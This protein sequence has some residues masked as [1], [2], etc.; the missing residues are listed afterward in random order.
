MYFFYFLNKNLSQKT[1]EEKRFAL[2]EKTEKSTP[3]P[4]TPAPAPSPHNH[5]TTL[6]NTNNVHTFCT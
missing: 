4:P 1:G 3:T 5:N 2:S 6:K